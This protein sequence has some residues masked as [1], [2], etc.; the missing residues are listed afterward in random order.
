MRTGFKILALAF[1]SAIF[2][3]SCD[4]DSP[5]K[6]VQRAFEAMFPEAGRVDWDLE[7]G[8][9]V[10][11]FYENGYE[12]EAWFDKNGIWLLTKTEYEGRV[13]DLIKNAVGNTEYSDWWIDDVDFIEKK[14]VDSF[15]V[16]EVEQGGIERNLY[17]SESG[18]WIEK[19]QITIFP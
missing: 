8:Y 17:F 10:A 3:Q 2:L 13:S 12:K 7:R 11:D 5:D 1:F 4:D 15:F 9:Y 19:D 14:D 18:E 16:V 6:D